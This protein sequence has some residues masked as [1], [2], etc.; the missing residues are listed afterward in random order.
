MRPLI[1][2]ILQNIFMQLMLFNMHVLSMLD[3]LMAVLN[4]D[5]QVEELIVFDFLQSSLNL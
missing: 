3:S 1:Q 4:K 5:I 2:E